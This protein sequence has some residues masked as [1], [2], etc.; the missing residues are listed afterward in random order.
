M[1]QANHEGLKLNGLHYLLVY[2]ENVK[3]L[4]KNLHIIHKN[5]KALF[6]SNKE[7]E[8]EVNVE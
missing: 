6:V 5:T 4:G 2:A 3:L 7:T 8:L 1:Q